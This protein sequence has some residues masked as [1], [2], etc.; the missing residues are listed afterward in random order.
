MGSIVRSVLGILLGSI[1]CSMLILAV[2]FLGQLVYPLPDGFDR[3]DMEAMKALLANA[4]T[5]ALLI[6]LLAYGVGTLAGAWLAAVIARRA[7]MIHGMVV[8]GLHLLFSVA[9]MLMLPH[10]AWF[11]IP[12]LAI[13][14]VAGYVGVKLV[15]TRTSLAVPERPI[16]AG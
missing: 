15:P 7:P 9:N 12:G 16:Q 3:N 13:F 1:L 11:W 2:E 5:G 8:A 14:P 10:P 6:V 4:P